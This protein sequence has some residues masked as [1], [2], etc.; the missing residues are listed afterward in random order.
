MAAVPTL[1]A[2]PSPAASGGT[3]RLRHVFS[4][5]VLLGALLVAA[6]FSQARNT[7][8]DPDTWWHMAVGQRILA[9]H[10]L[11]WSD[12]YSATVAGA[13]WI[14]YEWLGE[15]AMGA[16]AFFAGLR[17]AS[18]LLIF[19]SGLLMLLLYYY[20]SLKCR[21]SKAAF[22]ACAVLLPVLAAFFTLRPQLFGA[23][24]LVLTLIALE[25]FRRGRERALWFLPPLFLVWVNTHGSFVFGL[26]ALG[27]TW[28]CGQLEFSAGGWFAER[29][30]RRRSVQLLLAFLASTLVLPLTPYGTRLAA[31]PL[32]MAFT[33]P[34]NTSNIQ[35]WL[36]LETR[37]FFGGYIAG[38][39]LLF[40]LAALLQR[41][42]FRLSD[43]LLASFA[44]MAAC[45]HVRFVLLLGIFLAPLIA[46]IFADWL[47]SYQPEKDH[48]FL[49]AAL[50]ALA[51][52]GMSSFFPTRGDLG[53]QVDKA[54]PREAVQFLSAHSVQGT[55][56]N[57]YGWGGYLIWSGRPRNEIFIDG[58]ADVYEYAGVLADYMSIVHLAPNAMQLLKKYNVQACL[59]RRDVALATVLSNA[60]DWQRVYADQLAA[61]Y[62]KKLDSRAP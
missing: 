2:P 52:I 40:F 39:L 44:A 54:Y 22:V 46:G 55:L 5:P 16:A 28:L 21:N 33:Q 42:R 13:P 32:A 36:P 60:P 31:Y 50:I 62:V 24:F 12:P 47:P 29:W 3:S 35:E 51:A 25:H 11:P 7:L 19:L 20:A 4:F 8:L 14:A 27:A 18:F 34:L 38:L 15:A 48:P 61:I 43:L 56:L 26:L 23:I 1:A 59:I 45:L 41:P 6:A 30:S 9:T 53:R 57:D 10:A 49:N 17:S 58:R 37:G